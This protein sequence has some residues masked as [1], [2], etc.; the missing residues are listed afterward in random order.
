MSSEHLRLMGVS[1]HDPRPQPTIPVRRVV[2]ALV[3]SAAA[4]LALGDDPQSSATSPDPL[5]PATEGDTQP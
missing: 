2:A 5:T 4:L 1:L 3:L